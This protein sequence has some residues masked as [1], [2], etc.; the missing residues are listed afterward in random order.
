MINW[1][2]RLTDRKKANLFRQRRVLESPQD[3]QVRIG[4]QEYLSFCSNDYLGLANDPRVIE[5]LKRGADQWG[6]GAGASHLI[7]GH[8]RIHEQL[9]EELADF[10][11]ATRALLFSTG[12]MANLAIASSLASREATL[13]EDKLNH[14]SL[15]DAVRLSRAKSRRYA[16]ADARS[17][18]EHLTQTSE[19][20]PGKTAADK[21]IFTDAVFS[22]DGDLAPLPELT[23]LARDH[24]AYLVVDDAHGMGILGKSG[25]GTLEHYGIPVTESVILMATLGK[26]LGVFGAFVAG[27]EDLIETL[28]QEARTYIYT[29]A[30]PPAMAQALLTSLDIVRKEPERRDQLK[31]HVRYFRQQAQEL[32]LELMNSDTPIQPLM[33]GRAETA[34][35]ISEKLK[36]KG[37]LVPAIRPPTVPEGSSRLRISFC[38]RH[39]REQLDRL[40]EALAWALT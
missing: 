25:A 1:V 11:G 10:V 16:H 18:Q 29:T 39:S 21:F 27:D 15:I 12:Y 40:L 34:L 28:V 32:G 14:A 23:Q 31:R 20:T 36:Q 35:K 17:L 22:M 3:V 26:A 4:G 6:V 37:I 8:T 2:Q 33:V 13:F 30:P 7:T 24:N 38:A 19:H 9:E 5:A